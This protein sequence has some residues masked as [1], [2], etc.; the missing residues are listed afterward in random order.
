MLEQR[1]SKKEYPPGIL[2]VCRSF[3]LFPAKNENWLAARQVAA[4]LLDLAEAGYSRPS[5]ANVAAYID[6]GVAG[7]AAA[8]SLRSMEEEVARL[9]ACLARVTATADAVSAAAAAVEEDDESNDDS[10]D[11]NLLE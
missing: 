5:A 2:R 9:R 11:D 8:A 10:D 3:Y 1:E 6:T 7:E 4:G